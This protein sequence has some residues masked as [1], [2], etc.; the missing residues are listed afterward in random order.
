M[1]KGGP[2]FSPAQIAAHRAENAKW[3]VVISGSDPLYRTEVPGGWLYR[4]MDGRGITS[5][6]V[7]LCF[8]PAL[9]LKETTKD[10]AG[11]PVGSLV[12]G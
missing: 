10:P 4:S 2:T 3:E 8:V 5:K 11:L 6:T 12:V 7:A 1:A 9:N